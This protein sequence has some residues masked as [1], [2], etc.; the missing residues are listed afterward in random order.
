MARIAIVKVRSPHDVEWELPHSA[1]LA[2][3]MT[4]L[5]SFRDRLKSTAGQSFMPQLTLPYLAA[6]G[7]AYNAS[8]NTDHRFELIDDHERCI[9]LTGFDMVWFTAVSPT[10]HAIYRLSDRARSQGI[11]TVIGGIHATMVPDEAAPHAHALALG[12]GEPVVAEILADFDSPDGPRL[13]PVYRGS[14]TGSLDGLPLPR[15]NDSRLADYCPWVVPVQTSRGCRN[16]C[17]FCST[18]RYQGGRRRHRPIREVVSEIRLLQDHGVLT[19]NKVV[20]FTDNNIVSDSD[21]R[22]GVKD[23]SYARALFSALEPLSIHWIGQ[24]EINVAEDPDLTAQMARSGCISLL[25]G[26]ETIQQRNLQAV[27]KPSNNVE[28]YIERIQTL[29]DH[30]IS[31]FGCFIFG[32]DHDGPD[33]FEQTRGFI[34]EQIDVPQISLLTPFPGTA[35]YRRLKR[36]GRLLHEDW[37]QYDITH[38]VFRPLGMTSE[39][40]DEGYVELC[41][42]VYAFPAMLKRALRHASRRTSY[43]HPRMTF[44]SR[45]SSVFAPN[46]IYSRLPQIGRQRR[47]WLDDLKELQWRPW[48]W[49][50]PSLAF[51]L[52]LT[53][54]IPWPQLVPGR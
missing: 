10:A 5:T 49:S 12:E 23:T 19:R 4:G 32:L 31:I 24:G 47:S 28:T 41:E 51:D 18:T 2:L 21:H 16:A 25:I 34:E 11:L 44:G 14:P 54:P 52:D 26:F 6:L 35:L 29:H 46:L 22:R 8:H 38:A 48:R 39:Q 36:E 50:L 40:L 27:G 45:I 7:H 3:T 9:D 15:W 43:S 30:D 42:R 37:S 17:S 1:E 53:L 33:V 13:K 20:F